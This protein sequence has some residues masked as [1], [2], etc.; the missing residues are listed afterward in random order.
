MDAPFYSVRMVNNE[1]D[2]PAVSQWWPAHGWPAIPQAFLPKG[3]IIVEHG[4]AMR[5][6]AWLYMDNSTGVAMM[7]WTVTNPDNT[8]RESLKALNLLFG[9]IKTMALDNDYG[10]I[11]TA[12]KHEGLIKVYEKSG[13][14]KTDDGVTH[15][16]LL[17]KV[18]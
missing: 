14:K 18:Q 10:V 6:A 17:T 12:A 9:G 7:E 1:L 2:Y 16:L 5:A 11:L 13:F 8:P 15:L 4:G 3:G